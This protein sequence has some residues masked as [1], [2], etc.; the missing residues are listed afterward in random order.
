[1]NEFIAQFLLESREL[2]EQAAQDLLAL[3]ETPGDRDRLDSAFRTFHTLKGGAGIVEFTAM[4]RAMHAAEDALGGVRAGHDPVTAAL[5][6]NCLFCVDQVIQWLDAMQAAGEIPS[7]AEAEAAAVLFRFGKS[8]V[9]SGENAGPR[10]GR[11]TWVEDLLARHASLHGTIRTAILYT[12]GS[13]CF[14]QG[15]DPLLTISKLPGLAA[16]ELT[17]RDTEAMLGAFDPFACRTI[18]AALS[19]APADEVRRAL[20]H[21]QNEVEVADVSTEQPA[22]R[23]PGQLTPAARALLEGQIQLLAENLEDGFAG[24]LASAGRV[25]ANALRHR[26]RFAD[27]DQIESALLRSQIHHEPRFLSE[28]L[29]A[30][31]DMDVAA[32]LPPP[33]SHARPREEIVARSLRVD[34]ARIDALVKLTGELTVVKNAIGHAAQLAQA[35]GDLKTIAAVLKEGHALLE[36]RVAELQHSVLSIRVLPLRH[37]FQRFPRSVRELSESLGKPAK[38]IIEGEE[39][40]ADKTVVEALFE[41][42][43]HIIRNA[44]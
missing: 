25:G 9:P 44:V 3:E 34:V 24:R 33:E 8:V 4:E 40:E 18:L 30:A 42:L 19:T 38:L 16:L 37:V 43:L 17:A 36:A 5:I 32:T 6:N 10:P 11:D 39:T 26:D 2:A 7:G 29:K 14:F 15:E 31:L 22:V 23:A 41:P 20:G 1:M 21:V 13:E 28:A 27:A 12:P 35:G